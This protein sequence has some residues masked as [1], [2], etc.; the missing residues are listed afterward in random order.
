MVVGEFPLLQNVAKVVVLLGYTP[1]R[2]PLGGEL[3]LYR[4]LSSA[5]GRVPDAILSLGG[6]TLIRC[7]DNS[8][9]WLLTSEPLQDPAC[10]GRS[11]SSVHLICSSDALLRFV[12]L[13][14]SRHSAEECDTV[15]S[16]RSFDSC[17]W[18]FT[19]T[20]IMLDVTSC[21]LRRSL[22]VGCGDPQ[23]SLGGGLAPVP[24]PQDA[25]GWP[26]AVHSESL[27]VLVSVS[28]SQ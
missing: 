26:N 15:N 4:R 20:C 10:E 6:H 5:P 9:S 19:R 16:A 7:M 28:A 3:A 21:S 1:R 12:A 17:S 8:G 2:P 22:E 24:E 14:L 27:R 13:N 18:T 25:R 11:V 23:T